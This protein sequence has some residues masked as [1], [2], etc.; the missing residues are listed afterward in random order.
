MK[1]A[2]V[3]KSM[4]GSV[5]MSNEVQGIMVRMHFKEANRAT[6]KV[7]ECFREATILGTGWWTKLSSSYS[8]EC[9]QLNPA[10]VPFLSDA[11]A[12]PSC[13]PPE[14]E[15]LQLPALKVFGAALKCGVEELNGQQWC[16]KAGIGKPVHAINSGSEDGCCMFLAWQLFRCTFSLLG[17]HYAH[18]H[19]NDGA[20]QVLLGLL[21]S[22]EEVEELLEIGHVEVLICMLSHFVSN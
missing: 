13:A 21:S 20:I 16:V 4:V 6:L 8:K 17:N 15:K 18:K 3:S 10:G 9:I 5:A 7:C 11:S 14:G 1:E 22:I 2:I 19:G 12:A